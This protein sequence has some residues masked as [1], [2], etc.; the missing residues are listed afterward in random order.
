MPLRRKP[1][2]STAEFRAYYESHH[3]L[4]G[5]KYLR[6][7]AVH[8]ARR[9][10]DPLPD[11]HGVLQDPEFDVLLEIWYPDIETRDTCHRRLRQPAIAAEIAADEARLFDRT[12]MRGYV[13]VEHTSDIA[14]A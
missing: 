13:L 8:Y 3:R 12:A 7:Y 11:R 14:P 6:G 2:M 4:I 10:L 5:E 1:G 9:Y